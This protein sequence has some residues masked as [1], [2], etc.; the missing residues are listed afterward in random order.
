MDRKHIRLKFYCYFGWFDLA[1]LISKDE[2]TKVVSVTQ[3]F[4]NEVTPSV[5][6]LELSLPSE[7]SISGSILGYD[8]VLRVQELCCVFSSLFL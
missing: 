8:H 2:N 4:D 1:V 5:D 3:K 6:S 7:C